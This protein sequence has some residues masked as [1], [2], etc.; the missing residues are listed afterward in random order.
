ML[1]LLTYKTL[2]QHLK[3]SLSYLLSLIALLETPKESINLYFKDESC[4][5]LKLKPKRILTCKGI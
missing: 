3:V 5:G 4:Y 2:P 1:L